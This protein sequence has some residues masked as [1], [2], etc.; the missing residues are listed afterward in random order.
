MVSVFFFFFLDSGQHHNILVLIYTAR[1]KGCL[2][3]DGSGG[4][5]YYCRSLLRSAQMMWNTAPGLLLRPCQFSPI[6][7]LL[8][9]CF[10]STNKNF[11]TEVMNPRKFVWKELR[12]RALDLKVVLSPIM[13]VKNKNKTKT[14]MDAS[15]P[16]KHC[17]MGANRHNKAWNCVYT[18]S[19]RRGSRGGA[20]SSRWQW[21]AGEDLC[22]FPLNEPK[23]SLFSRMGNFSVF[24]P[25]VQIK[26]F[27]VSS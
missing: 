21:L 5:G 14:N 15:R 22:T 26:C 6:V 25:G 20:G 23:L 11:I 17:F 24:C 3:G 2:L 18:W 9:S 10:L 4:S 8:P 19:E 1:L 12:D 27:T 7:A 13:T 16:A